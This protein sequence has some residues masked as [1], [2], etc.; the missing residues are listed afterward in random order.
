MHKSTQPHPLCTGTY[1][2]SSLVKVGSQEGIGVVH[3]SVEL[4]C[5]AQESVGA[6]ESIGE[7]WGKG[8][9]SVSIELACIEKGKRTEK[10]AHRIQCTVPPC[11]LPT[12]ALT[13]VSDPACLLASLPF[14]LH[15][16]ATNPHPSGSR[17]CKRDT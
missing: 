13:P 17:E 12:D 9:I 16:S 8:V 3:V 2:H 10:S 6:L 11:I 5:T 4:A 7:H 14:Y 1:T 15:C